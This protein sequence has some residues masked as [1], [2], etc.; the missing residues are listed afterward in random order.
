M[1]R[2]S[3]IF[4]SFFPLKLKWWYRLNAQGKN[5]VI[6]IRNITIYL[7]WIVLDRLFCYDCWSAF[8]PFRVVCLNFQRMENNPCFLSL[9]PFS[10]L[11]TPIFS[12]CIYMY[13][14]YVYTYIS[15][16]WGT[17]ETDPKLLQNDRENLVIFYERE[18]ERRDK[19]EERRFIFSGFL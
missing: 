10:S 3:E 11:Q 19:K 4:F 15:I 8:Y 7:R 2:V 12:L 13:P 9:F 14:I 1:A 18:R 6:R 5:L 16:V 17:D